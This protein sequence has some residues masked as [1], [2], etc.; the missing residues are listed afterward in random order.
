MNKLCKDCLKLDCV[1]CLTMK[2]G[3]CRNC[4]RLIKEVDK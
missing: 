3:Y 1:G 2:E 4:L